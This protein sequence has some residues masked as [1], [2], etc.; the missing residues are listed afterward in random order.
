MRFSQHLQ[1]ALM[2]DVSNGELHQ[3]TVPAGHVRAPHTASSFLEPNVDDPNDPTTWSEKFKAQEPGVQN[4]VKDLQAGVDEMQSKW[5]DG[6]MRMDKA[7]NAVHASNGARMQ[8]WD[9][10]STRLQRK[11]ERLRDGLDR[12]L[13]AKEMCNRMQN[14][15]LPA[16]FKIKAKDPDRFA[17]FGNV[18]GCIRQDVE[19]GEFVPASCECVAGTESSGCTDAVGNIGNTLSCS[20]ILNYKLPNMPMADLFTDG[21]AC[22]INSKEAWNDPIV[23]KGAFD[24]SK[25]KEAALGLEVTNILSVLPQCVSTLHKA[26]HSQQCSEGRL[27]SRH[28]FL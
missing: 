4:F 2:S 20:Y 7:Y 15:E 16:L 8:A 9:Q 3:C 28:D 27:T 19:T 22:R 1:D 24:K 12:L 25:Q 10:L 11:C 18:K 17:R 5:R 21:G 14:E 13:E 26:A 23:A 6:F